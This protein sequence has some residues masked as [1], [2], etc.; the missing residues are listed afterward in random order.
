M[1]L[2]ALAA[3]GVVAM[4]AVHLAL[5]SRIANEA[6]VR[7]QEALGRTIA[8]LLAREATDAVLVDDPIALWDLTAGAVAG[9][10]VSYCL[11]TRDGRVLAAAFGAVGDADALLRVRG[12]DE[13]A[14]LVLT[15]GSAR[16]LDIAEPI[17]DGRGGT[18]RVGLDMA[19]AQA[20]R[21]R[22]AVWLGAVALAVVSAGLVAAFVMGR[23]IARPI[24]RLLDATD[25]FD[26]ARAPAPV[27][28]P[29]SDEIGELTDR[30]NKMMTRLKIA[31]DEQLRA[32]REQATTERMA[33]LGG[34]VAGVAHEVN[35]PLAGLRNCLRSVR[36]DD[37]PSEKRREYVELMEEALGR[38]ERV[39]HDLL[40]F[41]RPP[42]V[43]L[44]PA[45][46]A[47]LVRDGTSLI[48][49]LLLD[50]RIVLREVERD[51]P[52]GQVRVVADRGQFSQALLNLLI[53]ATHVTV[54]GGEIRL[55][56]LSREGFVGVAVEDDGPGID[57]AIREKVLDPFF[58]TKPAG[59][60]TGLGL[61]VTKSI[62]DAHGGELTL[63]CPGR[64]VVATLWLRLAPEAEPAG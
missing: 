29:G 3:F 1:K 42:P 14:P 49:P 57:P 15:D 37:L 27:P 40:D 25:R 13:R 46:I 38:I 56:F 36:R 26:P 18:V 55:R 60:G 12:A 45:P 63:D 8:R 10:E 51:A 5:G 43:V 6:L 61:S 47:D 17:L 33:A 50:R 11:V 24:G 35:N 4:H 64:G 9:K 19:R 54:D 30:F 7:E 28:V 20:T 53:N 34:L 2:A 21:L 52:L 32:R 23:R 16:F 31:Y 62:A 59:Q 22:T 41:G 39:V 48:R 58:S 44:E